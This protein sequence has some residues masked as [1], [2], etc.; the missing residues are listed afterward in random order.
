MRW[1]DSITDSKDMSLGKL[2]EIVKDRKPGMLQSMGLQRVRHDL[3]TGQ[4]RQQ[5]SPISNHRVHAELSVK[6][7]YFKILSLVLRVSTL[8]QQD[9][10]LHLNATHQVL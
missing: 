10:R 9:I 8:W 6:L 3:M 4:Q 1:L 2:Q 5:D 7:H